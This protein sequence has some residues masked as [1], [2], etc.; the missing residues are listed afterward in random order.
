MTAIELRNH[1]R[2]AYRCG[3]DVTGGL[4]DALADILDDSTIHTAE[5]RARHLRSC[6]STSP[7]ERWEALAKALEEGVAAARARVGE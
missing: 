6:A 3:D 7:H 1:A 4:L 5:H 2:D